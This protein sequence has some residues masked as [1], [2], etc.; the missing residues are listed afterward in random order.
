MGLKENLKTRRLALGLTLEEASQK[1][2]VKR[3]TLQ[4]YE[5]GVITNI[6]K[7]KIERL[8]QLYGTTPAALMGWEEGSRAPASPEYLQ[9]LE[10]IP[11][12]YCHRIEEFEKLD[13]SERDVDLIIGIAKQ[14]KI[15]KEKEE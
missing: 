11:A 14:V 2:G 12:M 1:I 3:P 8:A 15:V 9:K 5:S 4:R 6:P 10:E 7:D 13:L